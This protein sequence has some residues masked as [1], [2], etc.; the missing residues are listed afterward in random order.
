MHAA[1]LR[2]LESAEWTYM[3]GTCD[4][5]AK[6]ALVAFALLI[7]AYS[8]V[9]SDLLLDCSHVIASLLAAK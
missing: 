6:H 2:V 5:A 1:V 9:L 3:N 8:Q 4:Y 7:A